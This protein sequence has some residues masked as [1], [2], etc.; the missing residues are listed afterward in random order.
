MI[1][2][3]SLINTQHYK[4]RIKSKVE[5]SRKSNS[6]LPLHLSVVANEKGAFKSPLTLVANFFLY[7]GIY[8]FLSQ[9][10][11]VSFMA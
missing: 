11:S 10:S 4:V 1:L 3:T 5:Q 2:D 8:M 6:D 7:L 9:I